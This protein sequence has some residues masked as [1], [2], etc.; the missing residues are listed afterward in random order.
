M[1]SSHS[2]TNS[3]IDRTLVIN[4]YPELFSIAFNERF[5]YRKVNDNVL[6]TPK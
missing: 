6:T 1:N 4:F 5:K 3:Y 2:Q